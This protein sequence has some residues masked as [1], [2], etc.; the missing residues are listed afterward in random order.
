[1]I[2]Q[3]EV[4][5]DPITLLALVQVLVDQHALQGATGSAVL[6]TL[7]RRDRDPVVGHCAP[8]DLFAGLCGEGLNDRRIQVCPSPR[9]RT[10]SR[11]NALGDHAPASDESVVLDHNVHGVREFGT[12]LMSTPPMRWT[13][14][15]VVAELPNITLV[16]IIVFAPIH[17]SELSVFDYPLSSFV[18]ES[19]TSRR[20]SLFPRISSP[21]WSYHASTRAS[22]EIMRPLYRC[23]LGSHDP[24]LSSR[25]VDSMFRS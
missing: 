6:A 17:A 8:R 19:S 5:G 12:E 15:P 21:I 9:D 23:H 7:T 18:I 16:E 20:A 11:T 24:N 1:M 4:R 10:A 13:L 25:E 3:Q 22:G 14:A 2:A